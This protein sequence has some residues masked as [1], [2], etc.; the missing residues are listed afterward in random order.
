M[1]ELLL[2]EDDKSFGYILSEYLQ[3]KD[4][5]VSWVQEAEKALKKL[6]EKNYDL[7]ILDVMLP[8]MNGFEFAALLKNLAPQ[9][10]FIFLTARDMKIDQLK[11]YQLGAIDYVTKP[12]D[13]EVLVA[14]IN[15]I[16]NR[17]V[18]NTVDKPNHL[19]FEKLTLYFNEQLL[20]INERE[21][22]LTSRENEL[23]RM[24]MERQGKLV[25]RQDILNNLWESTD[26]FSRKSMDVF[27]SRLRKY[28]Q[29]D[30]EVKI[31]NVHGKG[32]ILE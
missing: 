32:F 19:Q 4:F 29:Q 17:P 23:L 26:E 18:R 13:E 5:A 10:P 12:I 31:R 15:A 11:G 3:M 20:K 28:L 24:L 25:P 16:L 9:L 22:Q 2:V 27:I 1:K 7:A 6:Q 14:K 21:I 8:E 30:S